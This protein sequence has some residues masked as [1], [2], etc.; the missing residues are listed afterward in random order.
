MPGNILEVGVYKG[1]SLIRLADLL[2][3]KFSQFVVY[4]IDTFQGHLQTDGDPTHPIGKYGDVDIDILRKEIG[5][6]GLL[7]WI[8]L[9]KGPVEK[10]LLKI[11]M[12]TVSFAH[13]DCDLYHPAKFCAFHLAQLM[14][15]GSRIFF[16]D[17][18]ADNCPGVTRAVNEIFTR[19]Q[20]RKVI[21]DRQPFSYSCYIDL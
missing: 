4:G 2:K 3:R 14:R 10:N 11:D 9:I 1:G 15:H 21:L 13:I 16:D 12:Q 5:K 17:Y 8:R 18:G 20:I 19:K 7:P 6:A